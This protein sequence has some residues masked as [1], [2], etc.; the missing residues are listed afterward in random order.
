MT[1]TG[2]EEPD[3]T[4]EIREGKAAPPHGTS[5]PLR[6]TVAGPE[7]APVSSLPF[8]TRRAELEAAIA[9]LTR[10]LGTAG[11]DDAIAIVAERRDIRRELED[12]A[13]AEARASG[14]VTS[15]RRGL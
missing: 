11:D 10:L 9:R 5:S 14:K 4:N 6:G 13:T 1:P 12:L 7:P 2:I 15:I 3:E 8:E